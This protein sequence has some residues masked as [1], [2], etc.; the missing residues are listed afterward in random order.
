[1]QTRCGVC[2]SKRIQYASYSGGKEYYCFECDDHH[3]YDEDP[4]R[5]VKMIQDGQFEELRNEM[6]HHL[7]S[8][9]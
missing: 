9:Y 3:P 8:M 4:S 7:N 1:M 5:R 2:G 6:R